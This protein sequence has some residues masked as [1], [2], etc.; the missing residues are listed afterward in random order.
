MSHGLDQDQVRQNVQPDLAPNC[1]QGLSADD[2]SLLTGK[3]LNQNYVIVNYFLFIQDFFKW[4][5]LEVFS[6]S[7]FH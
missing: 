2:K 3:E 5:S 1:L 4:L 6:M 7:C